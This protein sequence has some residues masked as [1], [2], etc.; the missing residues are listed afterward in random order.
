MKRG[1]PSS[2]ESPFPVGDAA[3]ASP[4]LNGTT[5]RGSPSKGNRPYPWPV[6]K[7]NHSAS[8]SGLGNLAVQ[9]ITLSSDGSHFA[10]SC[11]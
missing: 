10:L 9:S 8:L 1:R 11:G 2:P 6:F 3:I 5:E 7:R 4:A